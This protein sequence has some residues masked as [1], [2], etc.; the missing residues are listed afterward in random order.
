MQRCSDTPPSK[1]Q[2]TNVLDPDTDDSEPIADPVPTALDSSDA[3][4]VYFYL[5]I[6][7]PE[8]IDELHSA[9]GLERITLY[10]LLETLIAADLVRRSEHR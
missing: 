2:N 7:G 3:K 1:T 10:P 5:W 8:T 9:L 6:G 4:L